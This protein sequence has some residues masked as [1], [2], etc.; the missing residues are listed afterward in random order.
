MFFNNKIIIFSLLIIQYFNQIYNTEDKNNE[1]EIYKMLSNCKLVSYFPTDYRIARIYSENINN[2]YYF[3]IFRELNDFNLKNFNYKTQICNVFFKGISKNIEKLSIIK[4]KP[5]IFHKTSFNL[6][7][8]IQISNEERE[9]IKCFIQ[10]IEKGEEFFVEIKIN[11]NIP[12][13]KIFSIYFIEG[14]LIV[15]NDPTTFNN[16]NSYLKEFKIQ[17]NLF[18]LKSYFFFF[19]NTIYYL[20]YLS[21]RNLELTHTSLKIR[22]ENLLPPLVLIE[23]FNNKS[24]VS[25]NNYNFRLKLI[26]IEGINEINSKNYFIDLIINNS[27]GINVEN[28]EIYTIKGNKTIFCNIKCLKVNK[29]KKLILKNIETQA[30]NFFSIKNYKDGLTVN[31]NILS[32]LIKD[33]ILY[34]IKKKNLNI[35]IK[36][37]ENSKYINFKPL[38]IRNDSNFFSFSFNINKNSVDKINESFEKLYKILNSFDGLFSLKITTELNK[39]L[40][41]YQI[42]LD[43]EDYWVIF[44]NEINNIGEKKRSN[45]MSNYSPNIFNRKTQEEIIDRKQIITKNENSNASS[46]NNIIIP[47]TDTKT[48]RIIFLFIG[49]IILISFV[50]SIIYLLF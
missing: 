47:S 9:Q 12:K 30:Y 16:E 42:C 15:S 25:F 33:N 48:D 36:L 43:F 11:S 2:I 10:N 23:K 4:D 1:F 31:I 41:E 21:E 32:Y 5:F 37:M 6:E 19:I 7:L 17:N 46:E 3:K 14:Q 29:N 20:D 40:F 18:D 44:L 8:S 24:L 26:K 13:F 38:V 35:S 45:K 50:S 34:E 27:K 28:L 39:T 49:I 22:R